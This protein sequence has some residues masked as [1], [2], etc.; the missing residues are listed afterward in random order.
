MRLLYRSM[1]NAPD[2]RG[3]FYLL[4]AGD[5]GLAAAP[6]SV[7][8]GCAKWRHAVVASQMRLCTTVVKVD[9]RDDSCCWPVATIGI[10]CRIFYKTEELHSIRVQ[11]C[12]YNAGCFTDWRPGHPSGIAT[13]EKRGRRSACAQ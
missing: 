9:F 3:V 2:F 11:L 6:W 4:A 1:K 8:R 13:L 12:P 7:P 5:G 10:S